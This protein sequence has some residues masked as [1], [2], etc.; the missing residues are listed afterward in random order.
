MAL[1]ATRQDV[2]NHGLLELGTA[3]WLRP[4]RIHQD[5][6][7]CHAD[8]RWSYGR[9]APSDLC[10]SLLTVSPASERLSS[11]SYSDRRIPLCRCRE[12]L[13]GSVLKDPPTPVTLSGTRVERVT[14][15]D[16][17]AAGSA[18]YERS[19]VGTACRRHFIQGYIAPT[20]PE[21][22]ETVRCRPKYIFIP[23]YASIKVV[24]SNYCP[25][26]AVQN[27]QRGLLTSGIVSECPGV[28]NYKR[29]PNPAWHRT[30]YIAV[31]IWQQWAKD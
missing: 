10:C 23:T 2:T 7:P 4:R 16:I 22:A 21:A 14:T 3:V 18:C 12:H 1:S 17:R 24:L 5:V 13:N 19:E 11:F 8:H 9:C 31:S 28:K 6:R 25:K 29:R 26:T 27:F 20:F 30:L 15:H